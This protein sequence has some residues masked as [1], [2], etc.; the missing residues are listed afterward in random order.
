S[1]SFKAKGSIEFPTD[2]FSDQKQ[3]VV[4]LP[5]TEN[6]YAVIDLNPDA[7]KLNRPVC[8][9]LKFSEL[10]IQEGDIINFSCTDE[11]GNLTEVDYGRLIINYEEDWALVVNAKIYNLARVGFT[12]GQD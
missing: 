10:N 7:L 2:C 6:N 12:V 5:K 9:T 1:E 11:S 8:M 4:T 3:I